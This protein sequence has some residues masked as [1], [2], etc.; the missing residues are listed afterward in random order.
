MRICYESYL[1]FLLKADVLARELAL[2]PK[3]AAE[4]LARISGYN[5]HCTMPVGQ[6]CAGPFPSRED[7]IIRFLALRP[8]ISAKRA[9][10]IITRLDLP[11][12]GS[13]LSPP[14]TSVHSDVTHPFIGSP[15][16]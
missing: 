13:T 8:D 6:K 15:L 14:S 3:E 7:L 11:L 5:D 16:H 4:L 2:T 12:S 1:V 10:E 9:R